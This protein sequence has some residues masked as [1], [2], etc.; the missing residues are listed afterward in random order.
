MLA[1]FSVTPVGAGIHLSK[2]IAKAVKVVK[3]S[4]LEYQVTAMGTLIEGNSEEV[5]R[6]IGK[7]HQ[8]LLRDNERVYTR[9]VLD[10]FQ[11]E[12]PGRLRSKVAKVEQELGF[13]LKK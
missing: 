9:V 7:A 5:F 3:E 10:E 13:A 11:K 1:E 4:G 6:V 12:A 8:T 2:E